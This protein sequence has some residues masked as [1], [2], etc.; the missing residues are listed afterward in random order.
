MRIRTQLG[1]EKR[2]EKKVNSTNQN[3]GVDRLDEKK[4]TQK[5][6]DYQVRI[7][8]HDKIIGRRK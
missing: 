6:T 5:P 1:E 2:R 8:K 3:R 4:K 7:G